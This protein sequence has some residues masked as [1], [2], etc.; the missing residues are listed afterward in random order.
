MKNKTTTTKKWDGNEP[1]S[2]YFST[3]HQEGFSGEVTAQLTPLAS[4]TKI[5]SQS[6]Q[7]KGAAASVKEDFPRRL[8]VLEEET[9]CQSHCN[10]V[11]DGR[12][13]RPELGEG[14]RADEDP[15]DRR[16]SFLQRQ[17]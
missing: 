1:G 15:L 16:T 13:V 11:N 5:W 17:E 8:R 10:V 3:N 14:R 6:F 9:E 2:R 12:V 4:R 7:A